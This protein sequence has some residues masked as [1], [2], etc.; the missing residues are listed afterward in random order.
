MKKLAAFSVVLGAVLSGEAMAADV[1]S[2]ISFVD[3]L[4][5]LIL[6]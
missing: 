4:K 1:A 2:V 5:S 6:G 3:P